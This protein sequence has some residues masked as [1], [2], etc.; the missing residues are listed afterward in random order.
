MFQAL[1][2]YLTKRREK[3]EAQREKHRLIL[4]RQQL[5]EQFAKEERAEIFWDRIEAIRRDQE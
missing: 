4:E 5:Q 3:Q 2:R 1:Q